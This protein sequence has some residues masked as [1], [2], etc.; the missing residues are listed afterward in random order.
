MR[1]VVEQRIGAVDH[2]RH[3]RSGNEENE[4]GRESERGVEG[5]GFKSF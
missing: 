3:G 2:G 4:R 5:L 1:E